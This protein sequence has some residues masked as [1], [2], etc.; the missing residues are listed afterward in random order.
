MRKAVR[1]LLVLH[2]DGTFRRKLDRLRYYGFT[3]QPVLDWVSLSSA[4]ASAP[5]AAVVLVDPYFGMLPR[6]SLAPELAR[7]R[8]EFPS[9]TVVAA[10]FPRLGWISD[11]R[12]LGEWGVS[13]VIDLSTEGTEEG[14]RRRLANVRGRPLRALLERVVELSAGSRT[15]FILD[16]AVDVAS[17]EGG[18][19]ELALALGLSPATLVRWCYQARL[20]VPR[21]LLMWIRILLAAEMLDDPGR[22]VLDVALTC[23]YSSDRALRRALHATVGAGATRMRSEGAFGVAAERFRAELVQ[24]STS[25][26]VAAV[27]T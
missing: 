4:L 19:R 21:R 7:L 11:V 23:G 14:I 1:P 18:P 5:P 8:R 6:A 2:A 3:T 9:V 27:C 20:P 12:A 16:T 10:I 15:R 22:S 26:R 13:E 25:G 24:V 17:T